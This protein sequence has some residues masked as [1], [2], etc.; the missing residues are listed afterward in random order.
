MKPLSVKLIEKNGLT[1]VKPASSKVFVPQELSTHL[2]NK[3]APEMDKL[4]YAAQTINKPM[5]FYPLS[6]KDTLMN[7]GPYTSI[8]RNDLPEKELSQL[9][10][11]AVDKTY[12]VCNINK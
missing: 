12:K 5:Y 6:S 10:R 1:Y 4:E 2:F 3:L 8:I 7:F 9:L 11:E